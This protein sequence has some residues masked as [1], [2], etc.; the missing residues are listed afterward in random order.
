MS[1]LS[2]ENTKTINSKLKRISPY[3]DLNLNFKRHPNTADVKPLKDIDAVKN[4]VKN[5]LLTNFGDRPF[6]PEVG[7]NITSLLFEPADIFTALSL[8]QEIKLC[9]EKFEPRVNGITVEVLND[10]DRNAYFVTV[11]FNVLFDN[12]NQ[13]ISFYLER[14]R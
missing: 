2:D 5:L 4:A 6:Q 10:E 1:G 3:A 7:S 12:K 13:E 8:K 14:L 11:A 9:L